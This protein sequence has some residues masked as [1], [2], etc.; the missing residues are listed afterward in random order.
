MKCIEDVE[1]PC[2]SFAYNVQDQKCY[3]YSR[4]LLE[5]DYVIS[6]GIVTYVPVFDNIE[7]DKPTAQSDT[8]QQNDEKYGSHRAI[9]GDPNTYMWTYREHPIW[10]CVD[11][12][13]IHSMR[14]IQIINRK[15][16]SDR[17]E[18]FRLSFGMTG[19]CD[20]AGLDDSIECYRDI[21]TD[22]PHYDI[23]K[24]TSAC[25][26]P[27]REGERG[28]L[29]IARTAYYIYSNRLQGV[30]FLREEPCTTVLENDYVIPSGIVTYV[31]V[32][33]DIEKDKP[34]AQSDTYQQNDEK[35]GSHRAVDGDPNTFMS[36]ACIN[37]KREGERGFLKIARTAYY[38]Y[39]NRLQGVVFLREEPCTTVLENDY[40]IPS[41]IVTYVPVFDDIEKDKPT[42]QSDTYQQN[43]EKYGSHR[44][45]DGDPNTFMST[46]RGTPIWWCVDLLKIHSMRL[47]QIINRKSHS[48]Q[49]EGFRLSFGMTG[50]C[51]EAGLDDS[52][53]CYRDIGTDQLHYDITKCTSDSLFCTMKCLRDVETSCLS[54]AYNAQDQKCYLYSRVL[55]ENDYV[56][57]SGIVAYFPVFDDIEKN[58]PTAQSEIYQQNDEEYGSHRAIDGD[59]N[60]YMW[61]S[62]ERP[63]WWCVDLVKIHSMR[64]IQIV[65]RK[66]Y[67]DRMKGFGL[68]FGM[69]GNCDEAGL[70][71]SSECYRD[72]GTDQ[73]HYDITKCTSAPFT[74]THLDTLPSWPNH[75]PI[76]HTAF[77]LL[78]LCTTRIWDT[79]T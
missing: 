52:I 42:A 39:S 79:K 40:V 25:I 73:P 44:A 48:D 54:F 55:L 63:I 11:L 21:G 30:V 24:C 64:L 31:P 61:S 76:R 9:D 22:Q 35:Y 8:Y 70:D 36:T 59:P 32:F 77:R 17:M 15:S 33:D 43:D 18:G 68:S 3:L 51:D 50:N 57:S 65:N 28:F 58:K 53:E 67:S 26:N 1:T 12:V 69:T 60:T 13:K 46:G 72:L 5:N 47:I 49:M 66:S 38:I 71:D 41:G 56:I 23:T 4:V 19:N 45:V 2:L 14:L 37:P 78:R 16:H 7:K 75:A 10:W 27:K 29:K 62:R 74:P 20:E 34:T 6:S